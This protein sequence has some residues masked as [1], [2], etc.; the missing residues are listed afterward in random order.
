MSCAGINGPTDHRSAVVQRQMFRRNSERASEAGYQ[1]TERKEL[2]DAASRR[3]KKRFSRSPISA[4]QV[5]R[6]AAAGFRIVYR[7]ESQ[8]TFTT[9]QAM[10]GGGETKFEFGRGQKD[11]SYLSDLQIAD[12]R[13]KL[14]TRQR[15]CR[16]ITYVSHQTLS[17]Q[18][19]GTKRERAK[20]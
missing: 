19:T 5:I 8:P 6:Q 14:Q 1:K 9:V 18:D 2:G 20:C 3:H 7:P 4:V 10:A 11:P 16:Q 12:N 15:K 13:R 17:R